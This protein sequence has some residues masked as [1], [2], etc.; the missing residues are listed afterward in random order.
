ML[1]KNIKV[2]GLI[3]TLIF[4]VVLAGCGNSAEDTA[5]LG[6]EEITIPYSDA[7]STVRSMVLAE[8]LEDA[9]YNVSLTKVEADGSLYAAAT[10]NSD[11][12]HM[13][14]WLPNTHEDYWDK[15]GEDL[16]VYDN[17]AIIENPSVSL[18]VP[19]YMEDVNSIED[20]KDNDELGES[21]DWTI[22]GIDPRN[23]VMAKTDDAIEDNGL[24]DWKLNES[25]EME[26]IKTVQESY[27][28]EEPVIFT[29]WTPHWLF[30]TLDLKM[31]SDP[32]NIYDAED[33]S[34]NLVFNSGFENEHP[35][36]Y[37]IAVNMAEDWSQNDENTLMERIF[38]DGD[39]SQETIESF[40]D[41][42][43]NRIDDWKKDTVAE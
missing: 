38:V 12:M 28:N 1:K 26:M 25:S 42:N 31:L 19:E 7:G 40:V 21:V 43:S 16:V 13:D 10:E 34:I 29:G 18:A 4:S 11:T 17:E 6:G 8:V 36:A 37:K 15:Y 9:G 24:G 39:N 23:G 32:D 27:E 14:G 22:Q 30:E 2:F 41:S 5:E 20:L 33:D 35:A 3:S